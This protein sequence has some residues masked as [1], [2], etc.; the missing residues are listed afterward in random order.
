VA[1]NSHFKRVSQIEIAIL[2]VPS[3]RQSGDS[4]KREMKR[5]GRER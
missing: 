1:Q 3:K 2:Q 5:E 4:I